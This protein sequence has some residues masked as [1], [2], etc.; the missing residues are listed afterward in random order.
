MAAPRK[1]TDTHRQRLAD[2]HGRG[3][4]RNAIAREL[5]LGVGTITLM[6]QEAGLSFERGPGVKAATAARKAD[7]A[8][9][10]SELEL[11]LLEDAQKLRAQV[12]QEHEYR[13]YGGKD[14]VLRKWTQD[15]PTPVDK[16]KLMQAAGI[17]LDRAVKLGELDKAD[18]VDAARSMLGR[19]L[20]QMQ[21]VAGEYDE[22]AAS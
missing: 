10:R 2:L 13:D 4:G 3:F 21:V 8:A 17:A 7:A 11:Q 18:E 5:G 6:A 1:V 19:L 12:W 20:E 22:A 15:E 14:F 16:L 9:L